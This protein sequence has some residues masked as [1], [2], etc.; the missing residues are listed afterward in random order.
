[1]N[2]LTRRVLRGLQ[3]LT[4]KT[5]L[6]RFAAQLQNPAAAQAERLTD[7]L[8]ANANSE[9]GRQHRFAA[10]ADADAYRRAVPV[11]RYADFMPLIE[12]LK[13]G[14]KNVLTAEPVS[15]F[16]ITSGTESAA[17]FIPLTRRFTREH[18]YMH[19][20]WLW[21]MI[22]A[23]P[24][25]IVGDIFSVISP[26]VGGYVGGIPYGAISGK[27]Y[28]DQSLPQRRLNCVPY[29]VCLIKDS[30]R[31]NYLSLLYALAADLRCA[32]S[33][34]P[35]TLILLA[36][37]L[38]DYAEPLLDD[39]AGGG[40]RGLDFS[41]EER[42][43]FARP[44]AAARA[45]ILRER[46]R[47]DKVLL[48]KTAWENLCAINTWQGGCAPF[49]LPR[50]RETWGDAPMRCWGLR[51]TEGIFSV[52]TAD[53]AKDAGGAVAIGGHFLEFTADL[54]T[55]AEFPATQLAHELEIGKRY[56]LIITTSGGLYRYDLGDVVEVTGFNRRTP[57]IAFLY[58]A[59]GVVSVTGEKVTPEQVVATLATVGKNFPPL[60][61]FT[62]GVEMR[63]PPRYVVAI[64]PRDGD[65][66]NAAKFDQLARAF[67]AELARRNVEYRDKR[68]SGRLDAPAACVLPAGSYQIYR[69]HRVR[70]GSPD[71]QIKPPQLLRP[72]AWRDFR[73][74]IDAGGG[75]Q[76]Q[77]SGI[78]V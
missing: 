50:V 1:M 76:L 74:I 48:P 51:A 65:A 67:D 43:Q 71:G 47:A 19:L 49:Y 16:G 28:R 10:I 42:R 29:A 32:N 38:N 2:D 3:Y 62:V 35:S 22:A 20:M 21:S 26:A 25:G 11:R 34:N 27:H 73:R 54:E 53:G 13:N 9:F 15:M 78:G 57:E 60:T 30:L 7:I 24:L 66:N 46:F 18:H 45:R 55:R 5:R 37:T 75:R 68:D 31:R 6:A 44:A 8:S 36:Q 70:S 39:L 69:E 14:E 72:E 33:A 12:R 56:R 58:K 59:G 17:K 52:P 41:P 63:S 23:R 77:E 64:E 40:L 4:L 61:D